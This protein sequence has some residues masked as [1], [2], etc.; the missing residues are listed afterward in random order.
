MSFAFA[1]AV[2]KTSVIIWNAAFCSVI[3]NSE[4][5]SNIRCK[6]GPAACRG[7]LA[8]EYAHLGHLSEKVDVFSYGVLLLEIVSGR[9]N[10]E[11]KSS[12]EDQ[13]YLPDWVSSLSLTIFIDNA[14]C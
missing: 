1:L 14:N 13:F 11:P 9:R 2:I 6:C 5:E 10:M 4:C 8:P 3:E 7:Y 12:A